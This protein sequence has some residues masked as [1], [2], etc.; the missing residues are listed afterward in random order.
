MIKQDISYSKIIECIKSASDNLLIDTNI[1]D[2]YSGKELENNSK[3][4]AISLTFMSDVK[5]LV[6]KDVEN[7]VNSILDQL[8]EKFNIIQR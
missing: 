8:K 6:D 2:V 4:L 3:S 5:T 1:F 7:R